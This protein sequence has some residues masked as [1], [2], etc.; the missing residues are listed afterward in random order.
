MP[1]WEAFAV[2]HHGRGYTAD[3]GP[4]PFQMSEIIAYINGMMG[5]VDL[6]HRG[7]IVR[8]L[9]VMDRTY[10]EHQAAALKRKK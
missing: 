10:L 8:L 9:Q 4:R 7:E 3:G 6:D 1:V 5:T 2:L